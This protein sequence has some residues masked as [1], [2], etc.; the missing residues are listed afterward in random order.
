MTIT[1]L[2]AFD[3]S[4]IEIRPIEFRDEAF[5]RVNQYY[6]SLQPAIVTNVSS[7]LQTGVN[8]LSLV[9]STFSLPE[10]IRR[11]C[12]GKDWYGRFE[13]YMNGELCGAYAQSGAVIV[14]ANQHTVATIELNIS[15]DHTVLQVEKVVR[16]LQG[17]SGITPTSARFLHHSAPYIL[18][19]GGVTIHLWKNLVGIDHVFVTDRA[20]VCLFA[21]YV[22]WM[23]M[24]GLHQALHAVRDEFKAYIV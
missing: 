11:G 1:K 15:K 17:V 8:L 6:F 16:T 5:I 22:G 7:G 23:H 12:V 9:V 10:Q 24:K 18:F 14:G 21:G 4:T 2:S 13:L 19:K 20:G 3:T